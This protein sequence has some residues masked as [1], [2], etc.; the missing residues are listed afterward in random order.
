MRQ[1]PRRSMVAKIAFVQVRKE[2]VLAVT[3]QAAAEGST[4]LMLRSKFKRH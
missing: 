4:K 3:M 1:D 2:R